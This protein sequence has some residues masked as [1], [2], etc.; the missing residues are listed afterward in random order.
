MDWHERSNPNRKDRT[1][2]HPEQIDDFIKII[3]TADQGNKVC[4][5]FKTDAERSLEI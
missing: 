2:T 4:Y 3:K 1:Q 5:T